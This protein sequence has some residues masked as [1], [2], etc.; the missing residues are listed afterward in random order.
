ML[1]QNDVLNGTYQIVK[2]IGSG[3]VGII[4]LAYHL[5]LQK[6]VVVKKIKNNFVGKIDVRTEADIMK[7]L[8]HTY[9]PQIY[10]F[11]QIESDVYTVMNY[12]D[13]YDFSYY[14]KS[15]ARFTED[16]LVKW[17]SQ[18][19]EVL[20]YLH[21]RQPAIIHSDIKPSNIMLDTD[22][23]ICLIDFN[24]SF[25]CD[26]GS[27]ILAATRNYAPPE[28]LH[29][30]NVL[31]PDGTTKLMQLLDA[32]SDIYSLGATFFHLLTGCKPYEGIIESYPLSDLDTGYSEAFCKIIEKAMQTLPE[33][34][35]R[36]AKE[37]L[38]DV[39]SIHKHSFEYKLK[40]NCIILGIC[41]AGAA[42]G[43]A[44][45]LIY[46]NIN[47]KKKLAFNTEYKSVIS[48]EEYNEPELAIEETTDFLNNEEYED[49]LEENS[50]KKGMLL[51]QL[52]T[53]YYALGDYSEANIYYE[54]A[55]LLYDV[56]ECYRD[57]AV[58]LAKAGDLDS[59]KAVLLN[60]AD[61]IDENDRLQ[62]EAEIDILQGNYQ[63][64]ASKLLDTL[65][66]I[67]NEED[68]VR[69]I[70]LI[71]DAYAR[72]EKYGDIIALLNGY[73]YSSEYSDEIDSIY[74]D[75]YLGMALLAS[76]SENGNE[77]YSSAK[78]YLEKLYTKGSL[79]FNG[80][81]NLAV[82][83][84][85]TGEYTKAYQY[86]ED[87]LNKYQDNYK[88]LMQLCF[89]E[90]NV[91]VTKRAVDRDFSDFGVY[92]DRTMTAYE[93]Q[94]QE[95]THDTKIDQLKGLKDELENNGYL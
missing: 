4:Y 2:E 17:M 1:K 54:E 75:A 85:N 74:A 66:S 6:Y 47:D 52:A 78:E 73:S 45:V 11:I 22:G 7:N 64:A 89:L 42:T 25:A 91:Q 41:I 94:M 82:V 79:D 38:D 56:S 34:R 39:N 28:Q 49:F 95:G 13:G 93:K 40:R 67:T 35:Y 68:R 88:V 27:N 29:P 31:M 36:S 16:Q 8:N 77:Y 70:V 50:E 83:Y 81:I 15:G 60:N 55:V 23:N 30:V 58:S 71:C 33:D 65:S 72:Q 32:R 24:I 3:G 53:A 90:Y 59:A 92:Y 61:R 9:L 86:L 76:D 44:G 37:M 43:C 62:T 20:D 10:D 69:N 12:I 84:Q 80:E 46:R 87:L 19:L 18:C 21:K 5:N 57:Y 48:I 26:T 63:E 51:Y 14:I